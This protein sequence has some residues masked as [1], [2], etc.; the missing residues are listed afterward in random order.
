[1]PHTPDNLELDGDAFYGV[2]HDDDDGTPYVDLHIDTIPQVPG[3]ADF[4]E[5]PEALRQAAAWL[6]RAAAWLERRQGR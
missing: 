3:D 2:C 6:L 5:N 4:S 1:M